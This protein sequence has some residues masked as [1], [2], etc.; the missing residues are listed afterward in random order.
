[1]GQRTPISCT[2]A[3]F[4]TWSAQWMVRVRSSLLGRA[5][6]AG[7][8]LPSQFHTAKRPP[9]SLSR[10]FVRF[11]T[12]RTFVSLD[13]GRW[14]SLWFRSAVRAIHI[15]TRDCSRWHERQQRITDRIRVARNLSKMLGGPKEAQQTRMRSVLEESR[16]NG[17]I[18]SWT[19]SQMPKRI[20]TLQKCVC[21][22]VVA[23]ETQHTATVASGHP[24]FRPS[25]LG[26]LGAQC[27]YSQRLTLIWLGSS[28]YLTNNSGNCGRR[29]KENTAFLIQS[30]FF[31]RCVEQRSVSLLF[32]SLS[33]RRFSR[34]DSHLLEIPNVIALCFKF[35]LTRYT[36]KHTLSMRGFLFNLFKSLASVHT[37]SLRFVSQRSP[38]HES[39]ESL[40]QL[41]I[42][43]RK[44]APRPSNTH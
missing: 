15:R 28:V 1:M 31:F 5:R 3:R 25:W 24:R 19:T 40:N 41:A 36:H 6:R 16:R 35:M 8:H 39:C 12:W 9:H 14:S 29:T 38:S 10:A 17:K 11:L 18:R 30:F 37:L 43:P 42:P 23:K 26:A 33:Q 27:P 2:F 21:V 32:S 34:L 20:K 7:A 44:A 4:P 22:L 13:F